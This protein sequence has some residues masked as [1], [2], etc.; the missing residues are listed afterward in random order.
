MQV[1]EFVLV[2]DKM[3]KQPKGSGFLWYKSR[4]EVRGCRPAVCCQRYAVP[5]SNFQMCSRNNRPCFTSVP[6]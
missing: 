4:S 1:I 6:T 5:L 2:R 3:T